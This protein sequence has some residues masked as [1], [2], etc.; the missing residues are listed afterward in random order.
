M[1]DKSYFLPFYDVY[2]DN[3]EKRRL[4]INKLNLN[5]EEYKTTRTKVFMYTLWSSVLFIFFIEVLIN[6]LFVIYIPSYINIVSRL[7]FFLSVC[8]F[9][10]IVIIVTKGIYGYYKVNYSVL[11]KNANFFFYLTIWSFLKLLLYVILTILLFVLIQNEKTNHPLYYYGSRKV[12]YNY[13]MEI[14]ITVNIVKAVL[15]LFTGQ[16]IQ[17]I[18]S[19][20]KTS[21]ILK[22]KMLK[23]FK[24]QSF[25]F[26]DYTYGTFTTNII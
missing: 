2:K 3:I 16:K 22:N 21:I 1:S 13:F 7:I 19:C 23:N 20:I 15:T 12:Y 25:L 9:I 4:I 11:Q 18:C 26:D 10:I 17:Y 6:L 14:V 8:D 5:I 24:K